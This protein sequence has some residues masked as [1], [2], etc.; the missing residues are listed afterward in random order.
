MTVGVLAVRASF[1]AL[2]I[3]SI[4]ALAELIGPQWSGLLTTFPVVLLPVAVVL[5][6]HYGVDVVL[7]LFRGLPFGLLAI[8]VFDLVVGFSYPRLGI[9]GGFVLSYVAA[10]SY[11]LVYEFFLRQLFLP[12]EQ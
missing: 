1:A 11:L 12:Q 4:T 9:W 3:L 6:H 10:F 8:V 2:T 7:A 5:H